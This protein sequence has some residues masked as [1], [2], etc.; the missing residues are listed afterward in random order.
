MKVRLSYKPANKDVQSWEL[1]PDDMD[2]L[3]SEQ[4]EIVG[5]EQWDSYA[6]W[7]YLLNRGN[8]RAV[9]ALLWLLLK[10]TD[11]LL[12]FNEVR[13]RTSEIALEDAAETPAGKDEPDDTN[14]DSPS[15]P[16]D[17]PPDSENL[18]P[19]Q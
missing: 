4:I 5:G 17:S 3:E 8:T 13:F 15:V 14:T 2:N 16:P 12:D 11:P 6:Q 7:F 10:R 18:T 1:D 9:R 19:G